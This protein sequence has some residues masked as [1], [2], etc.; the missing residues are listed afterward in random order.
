M[1]RAA[2][3]KSDD[4]KRLFLALT[5]RRLSLSYPLPSSPFNTSGVNSVQETGHG[6]CVAGIVALSSS[7]SP[8]P[9]VPSF[10][11]RNECAPERERERERK[12]ICP[13]SLWLGKKK[14]KSKKKRASKLAHTKRHL[15]SARRY[16]YRS[17]ILSLSRSQ[18]ARE[19]KRLYRSRR[20]SRQRYIRPL[21]HFLF[22]F[23]FLAGQ[24]QNAEEKK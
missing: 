14:K 1:A 2:M 9:S 18:R 16:F 12:E 17:I 13:K 10:R 15:I 4:G 3:R 21:S 11:Y 7:L 19:R 5:L 8:Y 6:S 20:Q 23:V 24:R 22:S